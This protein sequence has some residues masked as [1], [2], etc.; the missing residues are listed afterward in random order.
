MIQL[1]YD[2]SRIM[3]PIILLTLAAISSIA[4]GQ[5]ARVDRVV[6]HKEDRT[7][8]LRSGGKVLH[9]YKIALGGEPTGAKTCKGDHRTPEGEYMIDARNAASKF[10]R[11]LHLSYP[12]AEDR[13]RATVA[14]CSPGGDIMIH[15]LP[16]GYGFVGAAHRLKD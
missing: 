15:G 10:H 14:H 2:T 6:V 16:N 3:R 1:C 4:V 9:S 13:R 8:E 11:S 12:N 5:T 7:L